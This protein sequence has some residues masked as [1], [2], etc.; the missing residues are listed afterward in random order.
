MK[1]V[2]TGRSSMSVRQR[3]SSVD[4]VSVNSNVKSEQT[5]LH[6]IKQTSVECPK[7]V[8]LPTF[9]R[10]KYTP[11][12]NCV[13]LFTSAQELKEEFDLLENVLLVLWHRDR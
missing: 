12:T 5:F 6:R 9:R 11:K 13:H 1:E 8:N 3:L 4:S 2:S 7:T 10:I